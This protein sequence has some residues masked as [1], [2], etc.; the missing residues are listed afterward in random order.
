MEI[1]CTPQAYRGFESHSLR[2]RKGARAALFLWRREWDHTP[3]QFQMHRVRKFAPCANLM[4]LIKVI[5]GKR[6]NLKNKLCAGLEAHANDT[7]SPLCLV[8]KNAVHCKN[9]EKR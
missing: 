9:P 7:L 8:D 1:V 4:S 3:V 5:V 2:H 6:T